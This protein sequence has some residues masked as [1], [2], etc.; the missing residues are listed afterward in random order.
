MHSRLRESD[1]A[2]FSDLHPLIVQILHNRRIKEPDQVRRFL[3]R[4]PSDDTDP[5][6]LKGVPEAVTRLH[7][8]ISA[9]ELIAIYGDYDADGVTATALM[10]DALTALG[11]K[12]LP[13]IPDRFDEGY[14]LNNGAL[15][16]LAQKDVRVVLTVDCGIRSVTE[17][18]HGARL[19]LDMIITDHHFVS[20]EIPPALAAIR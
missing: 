12:V 10:T 9:G 13:Y 16:K 7:Q 3:A 20:E 15:T 6:Q 4:Q 1:F 11:G 14:G 18:I 5:F 17:V 8:A 2:R 19:G